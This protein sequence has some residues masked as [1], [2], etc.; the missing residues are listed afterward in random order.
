MLVHRK[1]AGNDRC[2]SVD[3]SRCNTRLRALHKLQKVEEVYK[4][5]HYQSP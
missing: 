5:G 3:L 1:A 2:A 4:E